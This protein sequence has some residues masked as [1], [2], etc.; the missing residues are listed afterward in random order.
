MCVHVVPTVCGLKEGGWVQRILYVVLNGF[1]VA[2]EN[3]EE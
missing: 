2:G 1:L 3:C